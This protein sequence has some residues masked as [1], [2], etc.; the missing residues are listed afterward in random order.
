M[1]SWKTAIGINGFAMVFGPANNDADGFK[2][3]QPLDTMVFQWFPMVANHWFN[4]GMV[5][6]HCY[7]TTHCILI[8]RN[9]YKAVRIGDE[10]CE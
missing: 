3:R 10:P 9:C 7:G 8:L 1:K 5:T 6:T 2:V 4:D